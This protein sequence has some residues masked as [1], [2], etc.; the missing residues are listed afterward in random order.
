MDVE[1]IEQKNVVV[2]IT[3][4]KENCMEPNKTD[5][6]SIVLKLYELRRDPEMREAREWYLTKFHP[7]SA[8][9]IVNL[10]MESFE[11]SRQYR[12][13]TSY[14]DMAASL[15][16]NGAIDRTVFLDAN[17][18]HFAILAKIQ[19]FLAE[20]Q[21]IYRE[22]YLK[23]LETLVMSIPNADKHIAGRAKLLESWGKAAQKG[24]D[25]GFKP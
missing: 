18:E 14:W 21:K 20:V 11:G 17:T 8:Q 24:T 12:M 22:T 7:K 2:C 15:V 5:S 25:V 4:L 9:D 10:L 6:A 23:Q 16:N 13:V 1:Y 3:L 19:P